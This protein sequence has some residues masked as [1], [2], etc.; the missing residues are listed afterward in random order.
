M[1]KK[2]A[3]FASVVL[4][5][6]AVLI[7][8]MYIGGR[9]SELLQMAEM[10]DVLVASVDILP[11][12]VVD[13]RL[14]Q[15]VQVPARYVQPKAI[16]D[17]REIVGRIIAV[18]VPRGSQILGTFL[19]G[20]ELALAYEVPR[21]RRAI[22]ITADNVTGVG[23]LIR[24]GNFV[25]I[26]GTFDFGRPIGQTAGVIQ[27]ADERT[28]TRVMMQNLLV[29]AVNRQQRRLRG[30]PRS[31]DAS[32]EGAPLEESMPEAGNEGIQTV[33]LLVDAKQAQ[34]LIL[35]QEIGTLTLALR[36]NLDAGKLEDL[37]TLDPLG[38]LNAPIPVKPRP[39]SSPVWREFRGTGAF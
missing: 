22:T 3:L 34:Q 11:N 28:E 26:F 35:A 33:T 8:S 12:T 7:M 9:E 27:Y 13:E 16:T 15:S 19:E 32:L 4:A 29:I 2:T 1:S 30:A 37:G 25:D 21:G 23:G 5:I 17:V 36:S 24:P 10:R 14:L 20:G 38:L 18:P 31:A 39:R 6:F